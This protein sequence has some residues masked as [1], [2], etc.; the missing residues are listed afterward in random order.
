MIRPASKNP[1]VIG[2]AAALLV[3]ALA[4]ASC[5]AQTVPAAPFEPV[6][7]QA[8]KDV[9]W[10]PTPPILIE[11]MLRMA[12]TTARDTVIDLG[13]GDGR[14]AITAARDFGARSFGLE[15]NPD[16]VT[17][18]RREA[19]KAGV[20][21]RATFQEADI[22]KTDFSHANVLTMYLLPNINLDLRPTILKMK[23]GTR[24]V[25]HQFNMGDWTPDDT[26]DFSGRMAY[27]WIV[28]AKVD[29]RWAIEIPGSPAMHF[30]LALKQEYQ[31]VSGTAGPGKTTFGLRDTVIQ[32]A[33]LRFSFVDDDGRLREFVAT[34]NVDAMNG[35]VRIDG[36]PGV[37]FSALRSGT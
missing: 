32:G 26:S 37:R 33:Q 5:A 14:I 25:S 20:A 22:Y 34:V 24:V 17:L 2:R 23:P 8:G 9:I 16:M 15:F 3:L 27:M 11:R 12:Q 21:N 29:G 1:L 30:T 10:V 31:R 6:V 18:S 13:A 36:A 35:E 28:P 7:G 19:E 4:A